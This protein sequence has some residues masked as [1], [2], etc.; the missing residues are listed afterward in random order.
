LSSGDRCVVFNAAVVHSAKPRPVVALPLLFLGFLLTGALTVLLGVVLPVVGAQYALSDGQ[1]GTLLMTLFAGSATGAILV[2]RNF[3]RTLTRGYLLIP[4]AGLMMALWPRV[5][6]VPAIAILGLGLGLAMTS[7]SMM[8]GGLFRSRRGMAL[9]LLNFCWSIGA[10]LCPLAVA[11]LHGHHSPASL[12]IALCLV[13]APFAALPL[14]RGL[15]AHGDAAATLATEQGTTVPLIALFAAACFLYVGIESAVGSWMTTLALRSSSWSYSRCSV[16]TACFWG[17]LLIGRGVAPGMLTFVSE[18]RLLRIAAFG[19]TFGLVAIVAAPHPALLIAAATG[20]GFCLAPIFP[21]VLSLFMARAGQ[22][23]NSGWVFM[24]A[25]FG[26]AV[27]PWMTGM[28]SAQAHS[29]RAGLLV[30]AAGAVLLLWLVLAI[31]AGRSP[32]PTQPPG[33]PT[34]IT[35]G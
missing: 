7:T 18:Q 28:V 6:A 9:S 3:R 2:R 33:L 4:S 26:G 25:G 11:R 14:S 8:V 31:E 19:A 34:A 30:P 10:T 22:S 24:V 32:R 27:L 15:R 5:L 20:T 29:L 1:T 21:L 17:A 13:A 35:A 23:K 12:G 16:A